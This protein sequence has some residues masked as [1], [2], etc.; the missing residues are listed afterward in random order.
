[1]VISVKH[2]LERL[3]LLGQI[4]SNCVKALICTVDC[5]VRIVVFK[6]RHG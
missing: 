6:K 1:M 5:T 2:G 3:S 4:D